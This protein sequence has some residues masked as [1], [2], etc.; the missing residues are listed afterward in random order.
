MIPFRPGFGRPVVVR[1]ARPSASKYETV[2]DVKSRLFARSAPCTTRPSVRRHSAD[3]LRLDRRV[4]DRRCMSSAPKARISPSSVTANRRSSRRNEPG[5]VAL[6]REPP[7]DL[8]E[9]PSAGAPG[10]ES[11]CSVAPYKRFPA[12]INAAETSSFSCQTG[13]AFGRLLPEVVQTI[14]LQCVTGEIE[15][16]R[17]R[18]PGE[19]SV[20]RS[21]WA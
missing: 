2:P 16:S 5:N 10:R 15:H 13:L 7:R 11:P 4:N 8:S 19:S 14:G 6:D 1:T 21:R 9:V 18:A 17:H 20:A 3:C 12:L